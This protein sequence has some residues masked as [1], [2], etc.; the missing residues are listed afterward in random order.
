M[1]PGPLEHVP[2]QPRMEAL[3]PSPAGGLEG[4]GRQRE[5]SRQGADGRAEIYGIKGEGAG[6]TPLCAATL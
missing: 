5:H 6:M 1:K 3:L 4:A 2:T